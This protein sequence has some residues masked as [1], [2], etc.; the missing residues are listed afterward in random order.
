M[1]R[2]M[3]SSWVS[4]FLGGDSLRGGC[5]MFALG[6]RVAAGAGSCVGARGSTRFGVA[7][8]CG[9]SLVAVSAGGF[10]PGRGSGC[11]RWWALS[12]RVVCGV[13]RNGAGGGGGGCRAAVVWCG[14]CVGGL[15]CLMSP[16]GGRECGMV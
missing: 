7:V 9:R 1:S 10:V 8:V 11:S 4:T 6:A 14:S 16:G 13:I 3:G 12:W 5:A 2:A 15:R